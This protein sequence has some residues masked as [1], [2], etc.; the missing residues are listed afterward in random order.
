MSEARVTFRNRAFAALPIPAM[1]ALSAVLEQPV[2]ASASAL[3]L[4]GPLDE[5]GRRTADTDRYVGQA[6]GSPTDD[7]IR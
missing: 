3:L 6:R 5:T 7:S 2:I 4:A 1:A